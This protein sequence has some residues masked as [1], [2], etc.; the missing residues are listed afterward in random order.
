MRS[1][2]DRPAAPDFTVAFLASFGLLLFMALWVIAAVMG[3]LVMALV[4]IVLDWLIQ[5][6]ARLRR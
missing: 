3:A 4:A 2:R 5:L 6:L 1:D